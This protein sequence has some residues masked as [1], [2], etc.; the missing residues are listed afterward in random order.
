M[1]NEVVYQD[2]YKYRLESEAVFHLPKWYN[3]PADDWTIDAGL[4]R[5]EFGSDET[6]LIIHRGFCWDGATGTVDTKEIMVP[7]LIHD[8]LYA[9]LRHAHEILINEKAILDNLRDYADVIFFEK[10]VKYRVPEW[11]AKIF[12][13]AVML[14]GHKAASKP[15]GFKFLEIPK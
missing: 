15:R 5:I 11:Q 1:Q 14:F 6:L 4:C 8:A 12:H 2:G 9:C 13:I 7:A 3:R 10:C